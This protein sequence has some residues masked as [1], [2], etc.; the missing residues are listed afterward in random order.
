MSKNIT[1]FAAF[2]EQTERKPE[3]QEQ[4]RAESASHAV[5]A[6][7]A[8]IA[9]NKEKSIKEHTQ[10][11]NA[12]AAGVRVGSKFTI[13]QCRKYAEHLRST[14]QGIN[15][16]G[17][18][19]TTIH[20]KGEADLLIEGFVQ[21]EPSDPASDFDTSQCPDCKGTGFYYPQGIEG[22]VAKCKHEQLRQAGKQ[23]VNQE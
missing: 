1:S 2:L 11:Q 20:R 19:A 17:G 15:N 23:R 5:I 3:N 10:T 4:T 16:P 12:P 21:P 8:E 22:G 6:S 7:H 9:P 13:E 14:G 18:Y